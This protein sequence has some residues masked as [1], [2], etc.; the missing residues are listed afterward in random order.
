[1]TRNFR[2][3]GDTATTSSRHIKP[4]HINPTP[5]RCH[6]DAKRKDLRLS[7]CYARFAGKT[8]LTEDTEVAGMS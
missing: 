4:N 5:T 6:P 2:K 1:M 7:F 3:A 8:T